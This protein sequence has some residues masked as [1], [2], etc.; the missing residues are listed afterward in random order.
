MEGINWT[1]LSRG[2]SDLAGSIRTERS[3]SNWVREK[4]IV[5]DG[6]DELYLTQATQLAEELSNKYS[7][8]NVTPTNCFSLSVP[9]IETGNDKGKDDFRVV[10]DESNFGLARFVD[11]L[12]FYF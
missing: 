10:C 4:L 11:F 3:S 5:L 6:V 2:N 7:L 9:N 12:Y 1:N 8:S